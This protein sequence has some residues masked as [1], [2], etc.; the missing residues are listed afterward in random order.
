[1]QIREKLPKPVI[2]VIR[3]VRNALRHRAYRGDDHYCPICKKAS[4]KFGAYEEWQGV[5]CMSCG[6]MPRH[7]LAW[8]YFESKTDLLDGR[9][10][11]MLHIA[12]EPCLE[13]PLRKQIGANYVTAD[14]LS[15]H[16]MV[17]MDITNIQ[18]SDD[19]FDVIYCS[20]VLEHVSDD[21]AAIREMR[22]VL[23]PDGW[24]LILVPITADETH[25]DPSV[26]D[27]AE[28][29]RLFG[30]EDHVRRYGPDFTDRLKDAGFKV[31]VIRASDFLTNDQCGRMGLDDSEEIYFCAK[32]PP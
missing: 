4:R 30:Q 27:P 5:R 11:R 2:D 7:R 8:L 3:D 32:N 28:R 9:E 31:E 17:K 18:Y 22:R 12:P 19:T 26:T 24:A 29:L 14:L 25:E 6:S 23:G 1:M 10:K 21:M 20:H 13:K 15:P 16:A